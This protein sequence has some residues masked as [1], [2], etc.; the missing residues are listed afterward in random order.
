LTCHNNSLHK[1]DDNDCSNWS[2][3]LL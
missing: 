3:F 1:L 2:F